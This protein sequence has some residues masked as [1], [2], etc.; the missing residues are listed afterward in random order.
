MARVGDPYEA[1][2][3]A[4]RAID[5]SPARGKRVLL[6]P[7][8]GRIAKSGSGIVTH[9]QVVAAAM[10]AFREVGAQV[11]VG[12]SPIVGVK[13]FQALEAS[14]IVAV[15]QERDVPVL[16]L[17]ARKP[18]VIDVPDGRA[19]RSLMLCSD[20]LDFDLVVSIPVMKC[21]M[22]TGVTLSVKNMKGC[23]WR[24]SKV[25]LHMLPPV[26][27]LADKSLDI[28]IA[29][30]AGVLR[31]HL[32]LIDGTTGMEG[33]GPSAG[34]AKPLGVVVLGADPWATDAVA[35][36]LMGIRAETVPHLRIGSERGYGT[37]DLDQILVAPEGWQSWASPFD[38]PPKNLSIEF[39]DVKVLDE[40]SCSA[41]QSTLLLYL[42]QYGQE[43]LAYSP[44]ARPVYV[45]IGK[46]HQE[47]PPST[48]CVGNCTREHKAG[49]VYV[50][51]CP[52]VGSAIRA[53][54]AE[55]SSRG[56]GQA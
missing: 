7:N 14:G 21:H 28:A 23:L 17:D 19:I 48:L 44:D 33:L 1:A 29:D 20:L 41:C 42:K 9:C 52:P 38:A 49:R 5:L 4:L 51:G 32:C 54:V 13:E 36:R 18:T 10:D 31:P 56:K 24:R 30:M 53:A 40:A 15:A 37:L 3:Q 12:D 50:A 55:S 8:I 11:S 39:Q 25:E 45:A 16:D 46:G 34:R 22:H 27:G 43:L 26:E 47:V 35:C 6:K 2:R